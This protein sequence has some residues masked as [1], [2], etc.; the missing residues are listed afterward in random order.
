MSMMVVLEHEDLV[1]LVCGTHPN[2]DLFS[3]LNMYGDYS[4][5]RGWVW[6]KYS[7]KSVSDDELWEMYYKIK[8]SW[9]VM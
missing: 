5:T 3:E 2:Y 7:L 8:K 4:E 9:E 1:N 6:K